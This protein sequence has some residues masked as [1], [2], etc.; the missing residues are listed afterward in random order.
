MAYRLFLRSSFKP[1]AWRRRNQTRAQQRAR[2]AQ[3]HPLALAYVAARSGH[4]QRV[5][6]ELGM[7]SPGGRPL[8]ME[9]VMTRLGDAMGLFCF[10][11]LGV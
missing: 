4:P 2:R 9:A 8:R 7:T 10:F 1:P 6:W 11:A 5:R 3:P